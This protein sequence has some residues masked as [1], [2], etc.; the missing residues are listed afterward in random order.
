MTHSTENAAN[1]STVTQNKH[2]TRMKQNETKTSPMIK[3]WNKIQKTL[4][5]S[6]I[7]PGLK[8]PWEKE[9]EKELKRRK[10]HVRQRIQQYNIESQQP[11]P[12]EPCLS[13]DT[14]ELLRKIL[15]TESSK[16]SSLGSELLQFAKQKKQV[17]FRDTVSVYSDSEEESEYSEVNSDDEGWNEPESALCEEFVSLRN[18]DAQTSKDVISRTWTP[19]LERSSPILMKR[20]FT[21]PGVSRSS[22]ALATVPSVAERAS[23]ILRNRPQASNGST[24]LHKAIPKALFL[25]LPIATDSPSATPSESPT[26][27]PDTP[28]EAIEPDIKG[29]TKA[30]ATRSHTW[31]APSSRYPDPKPWMALPWKLDPLDDCSSSSTL[32]DQRQDLQSPVSPYYYEKSLPIPPVP[33][34]AA[35]MLDLPVIPPR[36][37]SIRSHVM[38]VLP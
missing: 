27:V 14:V 17:Q 23:P 28:T 35:L 26:I 21:D 4:K 19:P 11:L 25:T 29:E 10:E 24:T 34:K 31:T 38:P 1:D 18:D 12:E 15:D 16:G 20:S 36:S 3:K 33:R 7:V 8:E 9:W 37:T 32:Q 6:G 22:V 30:V 5:S 2:K 13:T